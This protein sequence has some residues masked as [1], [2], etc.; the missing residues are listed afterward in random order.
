MERISAQGLADAKRI[1]A[2]ATDDDERIV[3]HMSDRMLRWQQIAATKDLA[4]STNTKIVM[5]GGAEK[6][7][8]PVLDIK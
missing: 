6:A 1:E 3:Q 2:Q 4:K 5:L 8:G 7:G